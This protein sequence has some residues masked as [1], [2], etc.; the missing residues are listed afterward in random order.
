MSEK[1][2]PILDKRALF[3]GALIMIVTLMLMILSVLLTTYLLIAF[4]KKDI[5]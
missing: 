3:I 1:I 4:M 5:R 2:V